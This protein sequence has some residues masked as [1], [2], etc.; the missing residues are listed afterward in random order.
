MRALARLVADGRIA[1]TGKRAGRTAQIIC[2]S[3]Q[4][5]TQAGAHSGRVSIDA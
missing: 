5:D 4:A 3:L 1:D 2:Y